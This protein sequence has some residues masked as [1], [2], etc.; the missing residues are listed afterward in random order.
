MNHIKTHVVSNM[1]VFISSM[2]YKMRY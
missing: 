1:C 2:E